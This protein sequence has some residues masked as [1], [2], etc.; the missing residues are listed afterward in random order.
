MV[1]IRLKK[2]GMRHQPSYRIVAIESQRSRDGVYLESLGHYDPRR[3]LLEMNVERVEYWLSRGAQPT[4]TTH[5]LIKRYAKQRPAV[6]E[7]T[8]PAQAEGEE[9][10][11]TEQSAVAEKPEEP[12]GT[13]TP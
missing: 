11:P 2:I 8:E 4:D 10:A 6:E 12:E 13:I 1:K 9:V 5:R 7:D 3:K